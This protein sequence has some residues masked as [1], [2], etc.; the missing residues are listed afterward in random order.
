MSQFAE[1]VRSSGLFLWGVVRRAYY[2]LPA[3]LLAPVD[4]Y[5][6]FIKTYFETE[7]V[8][9]SALVTYLL[10]F[11]LILAV[12]H[13]YHAL[14]VEKEKI[15]KQYEH[16]VSK[17]LQIEFGTGDPYEQTQPIGDSHGNTGVQRLYRVSVRNAG[18]GSIS[19]VEVELEHIEPPT[20]IRCPVPLHLMHD[21][22]S[23]GEPF[24]RD[25]YNGAFR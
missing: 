4:F 21:N 13:T 8:L 17:K 20:V 1:L 18:S 25:V 12:I 7:I 15:E 10:G 5:N 22:P 23:Q 3:L 2:F 9:P 6:A 11:G 24:R 19:R 16:S 14:R